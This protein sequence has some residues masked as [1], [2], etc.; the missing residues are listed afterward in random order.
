MISSIA[1]VFNDNANVQNIAK[2][3]LADPAVRK[4]LTSEVFENRPLKIV[5]GSVPETAWKRS[6][7]SP[8]S[9]E[10]YVDFGD[11]KFATQPKL[12]TSIT[13]HSNHRFL[14]GVTSIYEPTNTGFHVIVNGD[15]CSIDL[16]NQE[17]WQLNWFAISAE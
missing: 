7:A 12:F 3:M 13:G 17:K 1:A 14:L 9:I 10:V 16:A 8:D 2:A 15:G 5:A 11:A 4:S 6:S